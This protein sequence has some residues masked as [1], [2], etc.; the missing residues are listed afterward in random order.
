V[1]EHEVVVADLQR[2]GMSTY[3]AKAYLALVIAAAPIN[4]Y[5]VAKRSGVPRSTVYETLGKLTARGAAFEVRTEREATA[6]VALP[7]EALIRRARDDLE[8]SL[9]SLSES[10]SA[11]AQPP[12]SHV[13][14][15]LEGRAQV[16]ARATDLIAGATREVHVSAWVDDLEPLRP[17]LTA[18]DRRGVDVA[19]I[20]FGSGDDTIGHTVDHLF[21]SSEV[22]L[23]RVGCRLL[24]VTQDR[25]AVL[26]GGTV[27]SSMWALY[28][29]DPAV[30]LVA[31]EFIRH[32]IGFQVLAEKLG[33]E[34]VAAIFAGDPHLQRLE[35]GLGAPGLERRLASS[36]PATG[37]GR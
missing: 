7:P 12:E 1:A 20:R 28:S 11:I 14:H 6:Y 19:I 35:R 5:E 13:S 22:V 33:V 37:T 31:V 27:G 16:L 18:A 9:D 32:D 34:G 24:V 36:Q 21:S 17:A 4:G 26:I 30:V 8:K 23:E 3:E 15:H 29:D 10:L 2:M 25:Q